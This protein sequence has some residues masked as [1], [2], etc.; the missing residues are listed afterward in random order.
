MGGGVHRRRDI[1]EGQYIREGRHGRMGY[2]G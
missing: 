1:Y 2:I